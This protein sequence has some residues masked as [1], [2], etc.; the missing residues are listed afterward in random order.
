[1][2]SLVLY[3]TEYGEVSKTQSKMLLLN[4]KNTS[5]VVSIEGL[6]LLNNRLKTFPFV[7]AGYHPR[8]SF[9][10]LDIKNTPIRFRLE[11]EDYY[12]LRDIVEGGVSMIGI[13][14][15]IKQLI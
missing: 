5:F 7:S 6:M 11:E 8:P 12:E 14:N 1:M 9:V 10:E 13:E 2:D 4:F 15:A 3:G